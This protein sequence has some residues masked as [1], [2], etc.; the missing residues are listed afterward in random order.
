MGNISE[1]HGNGSQTGII[2]AFA[3]SHRGYIARH[4]PDP[5]SAEP[6]NIPYGTDPSLLFLLTYCHRSGT[7]SS[8]TVVHVCHQPKITTSDDINPPIEVTHG[9]AG[10]RKTQHAV[11]TAVEA[12]RTGKATKVLFLVKVRKKGIIMCS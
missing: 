11:N 7:I 5:A 6:T 2:I 3:C 9:V 8:L 1:V 12:I 10:S 4:D